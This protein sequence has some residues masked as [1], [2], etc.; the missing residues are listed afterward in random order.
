M[1]KCINVN[2][3]PCSLVGDLLLKYPS[4][5]LHWKHVRRD[6]RE[7]QLWSSEELLDEHHLLSSGQSSDQFHSLGRHDT[8][9]QLWPHSFLQTVLP[10][11]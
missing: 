5:R 10:F 9:G 7:E 1:G 2:L 4:T 6:P 8:A 11:L 3:K